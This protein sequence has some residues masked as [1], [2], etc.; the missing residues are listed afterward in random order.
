MSDYLREKVENINGEVAILLDN[1]DPL[2]ARPDL[3]ERLRDVV[4]K[5]N[6]LLEHIKENEN[7]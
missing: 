3:H 2:N 1:I 6:W 4:W 7:E 5:A